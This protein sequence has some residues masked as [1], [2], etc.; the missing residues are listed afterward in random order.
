[1]A[2]IAKRGIFIVV[3]DKLPLP[4]EVRLPLTFSKTR[5]RQPIVAIS[6]R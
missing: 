6:L 3:K 1:M 5:V 2:S 4:T